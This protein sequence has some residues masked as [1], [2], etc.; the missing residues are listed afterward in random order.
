MA[1]RRRSTIWAFSGRCISESRGYKA[2]FNMIFSNSISHQLRA[3]GG[4]SERRFNPPNVKNVV[5]SG[6]QK[7]A[8]EVP[9][10]IS[11]AW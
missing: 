9:L 1:L 2:E 10:W 3:T 11:I 7:G 8:T 6:Q 4:N 5:V